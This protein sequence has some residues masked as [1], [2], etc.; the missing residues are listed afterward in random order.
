MHRESTETQPDGR[1]DI[2][3]VLCDVGGVL[4]HK[5][6]TPALQQWAKSFH[7]ETMELV[8]SIWLCSSGR[9]AAL[10]QASVED[11]WREIQQ[12]YAL[13]ETELEAFRHDFERSDYLDIEFVH[14]LQGV[15]KDRKVALLSNAW[16]DARY[17]FGDVFGLTTVSDMMIL[18]CE[19]GLAKP[20]QRIYDLAA[21]RLGFPHTSIVF[22]DDYPPNVSAAQACGMHGI[23]YETREQ[24]MAAL[25]RLLYGS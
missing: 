20:D 22:I 1:Y 11:V 6:H 10:G 7:L 15:R 24:T 25:H 8:L 12:I 16:P 17:I 5:K 3:A 2:R 9:R 19:E 13:T 18:S 21:E 4:I 14:F 23:V